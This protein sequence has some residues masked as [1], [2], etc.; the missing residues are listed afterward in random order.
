VLIIHPYTSTDLNAVF[1][2][3]FATHTHIGFSCFMDND[4][5]IVHSVP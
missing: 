3:F 1:Y 2:F 5:Y 4:F